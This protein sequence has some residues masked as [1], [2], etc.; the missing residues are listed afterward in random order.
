MDRPCR[1]LL[2]VKNYASTP[3]RVDTIDASTSFGLH[4]EPH[5]SAESLMLPASSTANICLD[6]IAEATTACSPVV[7][8]MRRLRNLCCPSKSST[9]LLGLASGSTVQ[10]H[11]GCRLA[12]NMTQTSY[13]IKADENYHVQITQE[14]TTKKCFNI[15]VT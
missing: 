9:V 6:T 4:R 7:H 3:L 11:T 14:R 5:N 1:C 13:A 8:I 15:T 2:T 10:V 12:E